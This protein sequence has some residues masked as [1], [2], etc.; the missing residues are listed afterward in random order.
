MA[1]DNSFTLSGIRHPDYLYDSLNWERYRDVYEGGL[2]FRDHYLQKF[3]ASEDDAAFTIR[4]N[5]TPIPAFAK[6]AINEIRNSI[7][8]RLADVTRSGGTDGYQ[9]A[10]R[11]DVDR[12]GHGMDHFMGVKALTE[13]LIIG[14][15][16]I[17]VDA[18]AMLPN[19]LQGTQAPYLYYYPVEDILSWEEETQENRGQFKAVLLRDRA[20]EYE[21][22]VGTIKLPNGARKERYRLLYRDEVDDLIKVQM[23]DHDEN[24]MPMM[25]ADGNMTVEPIVLDLPWIPF[26]MP[27]I[28]ESLLK[29]VWS[30]QV[31]LLNLISG[32]VNFDLSSNVPFLTIQTDLRTVGAHLKRPNAKEGPEANNQKAHDKIEAL[33]SAY[34]RYY[35]KDVDRP[36][37]IAPPSEPLL[38]S[39]KLQEKME[40][41]IR[42]LVHLAVE[43]KAGSRTESGEAKKLSSQGLEAGLSFIGTVMETA[44]Q[45]IAHIWA[46]YEN[47]RQPDIA[48][49]GYPARYSLK[50]DDERLEESMKLMEIADKTP[51]KTMKH[52][53]YKRVATLLME[54]KVTPERL[55]TIHSE[56]DEGKYTRTDL[57]FII[58]A[59]KEG[60]VSD[61]TASEALGFAKG[62]VEKAAND[63]ADR[64]ERI[65]KSQQSFGGQGVQNAAARGA[66]DLDPGGNQSDV[67][68]G[69][70][71]DE[72]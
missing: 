13:L 33:G 15:V 46:T 17:Y 41:D 65:L 32:S 25:D 1:N 38:A 10:M 43:G 47:T 64:L 66:P 68:Q 27:D 16:G 51:S 57:D 59:R 42:K 6:Q 9:Q 26:I 29:D 40:D 61:E 7:Y 48:I 63:H 11:W 58:E 14:R 24:P 56:I 52:E 60:L 67:D 19:N 37:F 53:A 21:T 28:G 23:F 50:S 3:S 54:D 70:R 8:Q 36:D 31:A 20:L 22:H 49:I 34:G 18:P 4:K 30:Y 62:E 55:A 44:E 35:D 12:K 71:D 2:Y 72:E 69:G 5:I 39:L 45:Q